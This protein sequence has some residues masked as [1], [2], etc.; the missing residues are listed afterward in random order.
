MQKA[1]VINEK[2]DI[3]AWK[4]SQDSKTTKKKTS[5]NWGKILAVLLTSRGLIY[6]LHDKYLHF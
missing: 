2:I 6:R 4:L 5:Y 3:V 1:Q